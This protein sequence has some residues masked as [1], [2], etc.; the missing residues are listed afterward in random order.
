MYSYIISIWDNHKFKRT[1]IQDTHKLG[2]RFKF[3]HK[4]RTPI[5]SK[6]MGVLNL[7]LLS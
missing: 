2:E 3:K 7:L 1:Q 6:F 5:K 4:F